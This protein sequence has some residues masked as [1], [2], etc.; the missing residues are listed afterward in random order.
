MSRGN[1]KMGMADALGTARLFFAV[2]GMQERAGPSGTSWDRCARGG[3][4][5]ARGGAGQEEK[6]TEDFWSWPRRA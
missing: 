5:P 2:R 3:G 6:T 1:C 4:T